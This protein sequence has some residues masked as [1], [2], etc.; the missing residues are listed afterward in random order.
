MALR[1]LTDN[2][3]ITQSLA[4]A[5]RTADADGTGIDIRAYDS[6]VMVVQAGVVTAG[7]FTIALEESDDDVTYTAVAAA[8]LQ[9]SGDGTSITV[10]SSTASSTQRVGYIGNSRYV[11]ASATTTGSPTGNAIFGAD[12]LNGHLHQK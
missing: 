10:N 1:D 7:E 12:I 9:D 3:V 2:V 6:C 11:R 8:D 5:S 4:P